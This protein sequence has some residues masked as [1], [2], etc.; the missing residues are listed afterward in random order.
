MPSEVRTLAEGTLRY[1]QATG[2]GRVWATGTTPVSGVM[3]YVQAGMSIQSAR[4]VT[5]IME[6]GVPDHHKI[7][8]AAPITTTYTFKH[9]GVIPTAVVGAGASVPMWHFEHRASAVENGTVTGVFHQLIG[10]VIESI[11]W[12]ENADGNTVQITLKSLAANLFTG[13]GFLS[14]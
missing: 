12:T 1:V 8:E 11:N 10:S 5:T 14:T 3:G 9:T 2:S 4:T 6:R 13:S 7:T